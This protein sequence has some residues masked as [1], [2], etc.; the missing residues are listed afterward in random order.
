[1][2]GFLGPGPFVGAQLD[3]G[4]PFGE[5]DAVL[6]DLGTGG[7]LVERPY[8]LFNPVAG[9]SGVVTDAG[10]DGGAKRTLVRRGGPIAPGSRLR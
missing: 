7:A 3:A 9:R 4:V 10:L 5:E 6:V 2:S 1:M 8:E